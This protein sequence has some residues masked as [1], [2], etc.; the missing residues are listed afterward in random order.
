M[1]YII[2]ELVRPSHLKEIKEDGYYQK[3]VYRKVLQKLDMNGI[4][5]THQT[6]ESA[7]A[8]ITTKKDML[9]H[10]TLTVLPVLEISWDGDIR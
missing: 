4:E 7:I 9:K 3:T 8:E 6:I 10:L 1:K 5:A 2:Y